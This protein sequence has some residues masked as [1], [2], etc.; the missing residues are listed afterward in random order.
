MLASLQSRFDES[1][2]YAKN[3]LGYKELRSYQRAG[4]LSLS[5]GNDVFI[6]KP[7]GSGKS[8]V[9]QLIPFA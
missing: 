1:I 7:T 8:L 6:A 2:E 3:I 5:E 9:F 4:A